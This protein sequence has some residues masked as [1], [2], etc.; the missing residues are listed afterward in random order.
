VFYHLAYNY[1]LTKD[2]EGPSF[3]LLFAL[4]IACSITS[5]KINEH[6]LSFSWFSCLSFSFAVLVELGFLYVA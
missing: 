2:Y 6:S 1:P 4:V 3:V 5:W